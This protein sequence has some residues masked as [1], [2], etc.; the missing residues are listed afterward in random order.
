MKFKLRTYDCVDMKFKIRGDPVDLFSLCLQF[1]LDLKA[2]QQ[3]LCSRKNTQRYRLEDFSY[4]EPA[5]TIG[6]QHH[7]GH[8]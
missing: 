5:L 1:W 4:F 2:S 6:C 7:M 3:N 8:P